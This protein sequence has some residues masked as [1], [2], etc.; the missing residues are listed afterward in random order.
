MFR[1]L[2]LLEI[3]KSALYLYRKQKL[4]VQ[5]KEDQVSYMDSSGRGGEG[6]ITAK[7]HRSQR[8]QWSG[9]AGGG[10]GVCFAGT[11]LQSRGRGNRA[12]AESRGGV[13]GMKERPVGV[14]VSH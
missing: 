14:R 11:R 13:I 4:F 9:G 8:Q 7:P 12:E 3:S 1:L 6:G 5:K 2:K 10:D